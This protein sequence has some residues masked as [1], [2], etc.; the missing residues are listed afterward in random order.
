MFRDKQA[1]NHFYL[2]LA[3]W[4]IVNFVQAIFTEINPDE[5][6]YALYGQ[7]L[8][9]G[10][11]DHPPMV[12]LIPFI[13]SMIFKG[14]LA[15][16]FITVILQIP[17]L[18]LIWKQLDISSNASKDQVT[19]FFI[20]AASMVMFTVYGF[21]TTPDVWLLFFTAAF[22]FVYKKFLKTNDWLQTILLAVT[23]AGLVY[24]KYQGVIL[25]GLVVLSN[26]KIL[27]NGK[28]WIA[29]VIGMAL[30]MPHFYWQ[31][32]NEFPSFT[33]HLVGR[34]K[35]FKWSY[36]FE[37]LP[38]QLVTFNPFTLGAV[39]YIFIKFRTKD[40]FE[41]A[42]YYIIPGFILLFW[43]L[44]YKGHAEPQWTVA[45]SIPMMILI[46]NKASNSLALHRYV[47]KWIFGSIGL[48][49][50]ARIL[51]IAGLMPE[52]T[53][54]AGKKKKFKAIETIAGNRPVIFTGSYQNPSL[55]SFFTGKPATVKSS[56]YS[57]S[58]QFD[59]WKFDEHWAG[60]PVYISASMDS[61]S[62]RIDVNGIM[63]DGVHVSQYQYESA[64][65]FTFD[66]SIKA[67]KNGTEL[68]LM[69]T[70][71]NTGNHAISLSDRQ[72]PL[73]I[74]AIFLNKKDLYTIQADDNLEINNF[75]ANSQ[76]I[77]LL[78]FKLKDIP[79]GDYRFT[80]GL[81]TFA[82][83]KPGSEFQPFTIQ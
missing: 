56:L 1:K 82:G 11:F 60:K 22:L 23:M 65:T 44:T 52:K 48:L 20:V 45:A 75:A 71:I 7:H 27:T 43:L 30:C 4:F 69:T 37:Y 62:T 8:A 36:F 32:A 3:L 72:Q 10:Y 6:Y 38:N 34:S 51:L 9:W 64:I 63:V 68:E 80:L 79:P 67:A 33:Y 40:L 28:F 66:S 5:A 53:Q 58:T 29:A 81:M 59:L 54:L 78:R 70:M 73:C 19:T 26:I 13:G 14:N 24:S 21:T 47:H 77:H 12:A 49:L 42:L 61:V 31:Y 39:V 18:I 46:C 74:V 57:R 50:I 2:L 17:T 15:V 25:I 41:K 35:P 55:Y 76:K 83:P 16:R